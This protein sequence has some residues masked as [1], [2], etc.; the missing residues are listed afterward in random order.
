MFGPP[1]LAVKV[2]WLFLEAS[3]MAAAACCALSLSRT[4]YDAFLFDASVAAWLW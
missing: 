1:A 2:F 3:M 4:D